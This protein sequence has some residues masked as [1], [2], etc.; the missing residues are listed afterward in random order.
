MAENTTQRTK[1]AIDKRT[2]IPWEIELISSSLKVY[3]G[4]VIFSLSFLF[5]IKSPINIIQLI[6][7]K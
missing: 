1:A 3:F 6:G 5:F 7:K 4:I 2:P